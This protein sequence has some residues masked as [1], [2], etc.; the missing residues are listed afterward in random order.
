MDRPK[1]H[2]HI[3]TAKFYMYSPFIKVIETL[4]DDYQRECT[5]KHKPM[6]KQ[7]LDEYLRVFNVT[8]NVTQ[9]PPVITAE[10]ALSQLSLHSDLTRGCTTEDWTLLTKYFTSIDEKGLSGLFG[11]VKK[12]QSS[13]KGKSPFVTSTTDPDL[14]K[15]E[16]AKLTLELK[17]RIELIFSRLIAYC[18]ILEFYKAHPECVQK[19]NIVK[20]RLK[21][22]KFMH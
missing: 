14:E 1:K 7:G 21:R 6:S 13:G 3:D 19:S 16:Q 22:Y 15:K 11:N 10:Y 2:T 4:V 5:R 20:Q 9:I 18:K 17:Q 12:T 8:A